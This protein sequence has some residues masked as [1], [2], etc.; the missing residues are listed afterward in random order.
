MKTVRQAIKILMKDPAMYL[1]NIELSTTKLSAKS[2]TF[3]ERLIRKMV[4]TPKSHQEAKQAIDKIVMTGSSLGSQIA[5]DIISHNQ[6]K[7]LKVFSLLYPLLKNTLEAA[8]G[9]DFALEIVIPTFNRDRSLSKVLKQIASYNIKPVRVRVIDNNSEDGTELVVSEL[10]AELGPL[11]IIYKKN[12]A[13]IGPIKNQFVALNEITSQCAII[14]TDD[15][16]VPE[17]L[18]AYTLIF[19]KINPAHGVL[20]FD[21]RI[22]AKSSYPDTGF[23]E[24]LTPSF[25]SYHL[26]KAV[27][28]LGGLALSNQAVK[29]CLPDYVLENSLISHCKFALAIAKFY[30]VAT[31]HHEEFM[32]RINSVGGLKS[33]K[34]INTSLDPSNIF[35][36]MR[37]G[38]FDHSFLA[39]GWVAHGLQAVLYLQAFAVPNNHLEVSQISLHF[40]STVN[41]W[42]GSWLS[43]RLLTL[44]ELK[45]A[46]K[47]LMLTINRMLQIR[48]SANIVIL[49]SLASIIDSVEGQLPVEIVRMFKQYSAVILLNKF[50]LEYGGTDF[51][52]GRHLSSLIFCSS[53]SLS[54][55]L[56]REAEAV[57]MIAD[58]MR[59]S[60]Y[61]ILNYEHINLGSDAVLSKNGNLIRGECV[62]LIADIL[63]KRVSLGRKIIVDLATSEAFP[64]SISTDSAMLFA[65]SSESAHVLSLK[66]RAVLRNLIES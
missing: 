9:N 33:S 42:Y 63:D 4:S 21:N 5:W 48:Y 29:R 61:L 60:D 53:R 31:V 13:N 11:E 3:L 55:G 20:Y 38:S 56:C 64:V 45:S 47:D 57:K 65:E 23:R 25:E 62:S 15:D 39:D 49:L 51:Q 2:L 19:F 46:S 7:D 37:D 32:P 35:S 50:I 12:S 22:W 10:Q 27:N 6:N 1:D 40:L 14:C 24:A 18:I 66:L 59:A 17:L 8:I 26:L 36:M 58:D 54:L 44:A 30:P 34:P 43:S 41:P 28:T 16:V 52:V